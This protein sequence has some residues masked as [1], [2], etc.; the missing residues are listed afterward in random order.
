VELVVRVLVLKLEEAEEA[1]E[2]CVAVFQQ[3][4]VVLVLKQS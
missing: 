4:V 2:V 1:L 3:L